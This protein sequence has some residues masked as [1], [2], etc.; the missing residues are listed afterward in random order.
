V[1][2]C[3]QL[4]RGPR[5]NSGWLQALN[6]VW[7]CSRLLCYG[8]LTYHLLLLVCVVRRWNLWFPSVGVFAEVLVGRA[9]GMQITFPL[10]YLFTMKT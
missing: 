2:G 8:R 5:L 7:F 6:S 3:M 1:A 10:T 9:I 4:T